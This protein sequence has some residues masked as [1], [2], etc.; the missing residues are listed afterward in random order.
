MAIGRTNSTRG[1]VRDRRSG[2]RENAYSLAFRTSFDAAFLRSA[3]WIAFLLGCDCVTHVGWHFRE[4]AH[5]PAV[6]LSIFSSLLGIGYLAAAFLM[7]RFQVGGAVANQAA[8][9]LLGLSALNGLWRYYL[10]LDRWYVG[11]ILLL[12]ALACVLMRLAAF[13]KLAAIVLVGLYAVTWAREPADSADLRNDGLA[14]STIGL[15]VVLSRRHIAHVAADLALNDERLQQE[16]Q[17][18]VARLHDEIR[19]RRASESKLRMSEERYRALFDN[20]IVGV[21]QCA[22]DGR[23]TLANAVLATMLDYDGADA[24]MRSSLAT[25]WPLAPASPLAD[26]QHRFEAGQLDGGEYVLERKDG[27]LLTVMLYARKR[28]DA[29]G[30][31]V[32]YEGLL[33]DITARKEAE[34]ALREHREQLAQVSRL[35]SLAETMAAIA[36]EVNQPLHAIAS[37]AGASV[38]MIA[39]SR[40]DAAA[41]VAQWNQRIAE[42]ANRAGE[43]IRR[44]RS[45][46]HMAQPEPG[47]ADVDEMIRRSLVLV[48]PLLAQCQVEV[49]VAH[50]HDATVVWAEQ[51][52][53]E[54]VLTNLIRNACE[55]MRGNAHKPRKLAIAASR[56]QSF[57]E[58]SVS[59]TG[60]GL[61]SDAANKLFEAFVTTK[62][63]GIGLGLAISRTIVEAHGGEIVARSSHRGATFSL[64]LPLYKEQ[65]SC[66]A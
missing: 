20:S 19:E 35:A 23:F 22:G 44:L 4:L 64:T 13:V 8:T 42:E 33:V 27:S 16:L 31:L 50:D 53:I 63:D 55:A 61:S 59:D 43:V 21:F 6:A 46:A 15:I 58:I 48:G 51:L 9:L 17:A 30:L 11:G 28:S 10:T 12:L 3:P 60:R 34:E 7:A 39:N 32:G 66:V 57:A 37:F 2:E 25:H 41:T 18:T 24:M 38:E 29:Q 52:L 49:E 36:H 65:E 56:G 40:D 54:Q 47:P 62:H 1:C 5:T 26:F 14:V 45:F